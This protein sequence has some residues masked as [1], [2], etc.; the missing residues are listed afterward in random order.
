MRGAAATNGGGEDAQDAL[1]R[2]HAQ[3]RADRDIQFDLP[4]PE[5]PPPPPPDWLGPFLEFV[6]AIA[7]V[8]QWAF[9]ALLAL[10]CAAILFFIGRE[11]I[12]TRWPERRRAM[13]L[14]G[15]EPWRPEAQAARLL[16]ADADALAAAG[17]YAEAAHLL[18]RRSVEDIRQARPH[19][20]RPALTSRDIAAHPQLPDAARGAFAAIARIV[21][22]ALFGGREVDEGGWRA[23]R[24]AYTDFAL[25]GALA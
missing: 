17:R 25:P 9:W 11:I 10:A 3:L 22:R 8:L 12:R 23:A 2:A 18:L 1:A 20:V 24:A 15:Q 7:P 5:P 21:E 16:L 13:S 14:T 19:L 4:A 6:R